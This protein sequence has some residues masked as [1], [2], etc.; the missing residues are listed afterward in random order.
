MACHHCGLELPARFLV[1][2]K[3]N[4]E[5]DHFCDKA[6]FHA[7]VRE[8]TRDEIEF[9]IKFN[10]NVLDKGIDHPPTKKFHVASTLYFTSLLQRKPLP[11]LLKLEH[12][13]KKSI[14]DVIECCMED[15]DDEATFTFGEMFKE[16]HDSNNYAW[17]APE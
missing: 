12:L 11:H 15:Q 5:K 13:M 16:N 3:N 8:T 4:K 6:C 7:Q 17:C 2:E 1:A 9:V 14:M 10:K